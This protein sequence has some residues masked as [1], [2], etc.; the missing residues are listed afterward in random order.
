MTPNSAAL[1]KT[2]ALSPAN[3]QP[4]TSDTSTRAENGA[5]RVNSL[6]R[7]QDA[8]RLENG[9]TRKSEFTR[10]AP[11]SPSTRRQFLNH[12]ADHERAKERCVVGRVDDQ[13]RNNGIRAIADYRQDTTHQE[14]QNDARPIAC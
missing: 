1:S 10:L 7:V 8:S 2:P 11:F 5:R 9:Y 4:S 14:N 6:F 13:S 12:G 3:A